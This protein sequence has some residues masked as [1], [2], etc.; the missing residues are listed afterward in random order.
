MPPSS[1]PAAPLSNTPRQY[2]PICKQAS[3]SRMTGPRGAGLGW[4][5]VMGPQ[6]WYSAARD[7]QHSMPLPA[8]GGLY[9]CRC[10]ETSADGGCLAA[11]TEACSCSSGQRQ[12]IAACSKPAV[13]DN[14]PCSCAACCAG[15]SQMRTIPHAEQHDGRSHAA[16]PATCCLECPQYLVT[17][18]PAELW[19]VVAGPIQEGTPK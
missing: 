5:G 19:T 7:C 14:S 12:G 11:G 6:A 18:K 3:V 16:Q 9:A 13:P 17:C 2:A 8:D 15:S 10:Q 1:V 4:G